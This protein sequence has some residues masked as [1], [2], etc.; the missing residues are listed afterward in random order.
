MLGNHPNIHKEPIYVNFSDISDNGQNIL[1]YFYID[2]TDYSSYLAIKEN[3]NYKIMQILK[4][5]KVDLAYN[6]QTIYIAK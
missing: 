1:I 5:E 6:T 2:R 3:V 4:Q